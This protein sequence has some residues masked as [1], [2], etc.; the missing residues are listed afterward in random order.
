MLPRCGADCSGLEEL[1]EK[2]KEEV[3]RANYMVVNFMN[4]GR[5]LKLRRAEIVY[6]EL[7]AK[8]L[9]VLQSRLTEQHI[10]IDQQ[11]PADLPP[12][13]IDG[14]LFRNCILNFVTNASQAM[15]DGGT[16]T[17]GAQ[18]EESQ[19]KL[20]FKDQGSGISP[21]DIA[22]IF[23]P[24]FTTKDVGIG[25]GLAITERII[26]EHGGEIEVESTIGTGTIITVSLP[27]QPAGT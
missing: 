17:L 9:P 18:R 25:L 19:V 15:P 14:E 27:L 20:T 23:Q 6:Q 10:S 21:D 4:Y 1:T 26:K 22:K 7:L 16:I 3:R 24:Y 11:I 5:P 13:W 2:I 8:V 12:L